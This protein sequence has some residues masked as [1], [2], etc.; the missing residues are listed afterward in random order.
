[1]LILVLMLR[2]LWQMNPSLL[3][4]A[5]FWAG[6]A[7]M[8]YW[9]ITHPTG[10]INWWSR[11]ALLAGVS[12]NAIVTLANDGRMPF[13][14]GDQHPSSVWVLGNGKHLLFLCDRF[15]LHIGIFSL[16]D[17][18]ILGGLLLLFVLPRNPLKSEISS[19]K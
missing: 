7:F 13:L 15:N 2:L 19:S 10:K 12:M 9:F 4:C 3:T 8:E 5:I 18:F 6:V 11:S 17:F 14:G 16:G 1:M